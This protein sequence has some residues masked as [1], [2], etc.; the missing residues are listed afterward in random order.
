MLAHFATVIAEWAAVVG[1]LVHA[2]GWGGPSAVGLVSLA[3]LAPPLVCA[4][5]AANLTVRYRAHRVRLAAFAVQTAAYAGAAIAAALGAPTPAVAAF[6]VVGLGAINALRP[7]GA[8]LLPAVAHSTRE[9]VTGNLWISYGDSSSA[10]VGPLVAALL[11][12]AGGS[13][14]VFTACAAGSAVAFAATA[15]RPAPMTRLR[16][17]GSAAGPRRRVMRAAIAELFEQ[18]WT[19]GVIGVSAARNVVVGALDVLLVIVALRALD[20][21]ERGPGLLTALV[22][23]GAV[24]S[25]LVVTVVVRRMQLRRALVGSLVAA[26][27]IC[28]LLGARTDPAVVFVLLPVLGLCLSLM[29]N[30]SRIMLQRSTEPRS[31]GPLFACLGLAGGTGQLFGSAVAQGLLAFA[32]LDVALIGVGVILAVVAIASLRALRRADANADVP[33]VEMTLLGSLPMFSALPAT[34]LEAVARSAEQIDVGGSEKVICQGET[35]DVFYAVSDGEFDIVVSD[36][37]IRTATRGDFFGE[38]ALLADV[39]RT[40]TVIS[41]GAGT[42]LAIHR[43]PF[44]LAV[45]GHDVSR[46]VALAHVDKVQLQNETLRTSHDGA[47]RRAGE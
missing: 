41:R 27:A 33:V 20:M 26:A 28:I 12:G 15:W 47:D 45:T 6:V 32:G 24:A 3:V 38:V 11:G 21:G 7:T 30:L 25:T 43:N 4:P 29:D 17:G 22:G 42:L 9:L 8:V 31:L 46:A 37:Y 14:A 44:L 1:V 5:I 16:A 35:G 40:A 23:A 10:L 18:Q 36:Q 13:S 19:I 39:P 2:Y 34:M